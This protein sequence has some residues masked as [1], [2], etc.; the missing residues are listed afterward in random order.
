MRHR[1]LLFDS[2]PVQQNHYFMYQNES[3]VQTALDRT[4]LSLVCVVS[5]AWQLVGVKP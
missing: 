1:L 5:G 3:D 2:Q 4:G